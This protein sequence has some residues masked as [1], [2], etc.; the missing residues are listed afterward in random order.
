MFEVCKLCYEGSEKDDE[1]I[2]KYRIYKPV[3]VWLLMHKEYN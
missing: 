1:T 2:D 3:I